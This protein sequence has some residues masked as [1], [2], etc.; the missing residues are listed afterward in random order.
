MEWRTGARVVP[1]ATIADERMDVLRKVDVVPCAISD[2][3]PGPARMASTQNWLIVPQ[4][5]TPRV[6]FFA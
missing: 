4:R 6:A 3:L 2:A 1:I 5:A